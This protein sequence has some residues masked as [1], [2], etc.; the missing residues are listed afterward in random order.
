MVVVKMPPPGSRF[1]FTTMTSRF[2]S[3]RF[4]NRNEGVCVVV[5]FN[6]SPTIKICF[7]W[8]GITMGSCRCQRVTEHQLPLSPPHPSPPHAHLKSMALTYPSTGSQYCSFGI[9][10]A[11]SGNFQPDFVF[12]CCLIKDTEKLFSPPAAFLQ[13]SKMNSAMM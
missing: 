4:H 9:S 2:D 10:Q 5:F 13:G 1:V 3:I 12:S 7:F 6:L 11:S 8:I